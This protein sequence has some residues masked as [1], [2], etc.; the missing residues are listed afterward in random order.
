MPTHPAIRIAGLLA[1]AALAAAGLVAARPAFSQT[2]TVEEFVVIGQRPGMEKFTYPI[3]YADLD[4]KTVSGQAAL[5]HRVRVSAEYVCR[6]LADRDNK[7][8]TFGD[9]R[10]KAI[11][12]A[13]A[14]TAKA[15]DAAQARKGPFHPGHSWDPPPTDQ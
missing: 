6:K 5:R 10:R 11:D 15:I 13:Q 9:C 3:S 4:L 12:G 7:P 2:A 8:N 1:G 14:A